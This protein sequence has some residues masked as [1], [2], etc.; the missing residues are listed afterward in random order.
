M[1][2]TKATK[3]LKKLAKQNRISV[4]AVRHEIE[5][6]IAEGMKS[7]EPQARVFWASIPHKGERPT[8][9]EVI[10]YITDMVKD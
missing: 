7:T 9:E 10:A 2:T 5:L 3:A 4:E 6:A 8:P 1:D